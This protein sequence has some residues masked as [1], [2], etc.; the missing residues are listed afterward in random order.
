MLGSGHDI[1]SSLAAAKFA[2]HISRFLVPDP[3]KSLPLCP[4]AKRLWQWLFK[5]YQ[6]VFKTSVAQLFR[7]PF[8]LIN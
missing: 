2:R 1:T 3:D 5:Y 7:I 6:N 4:P 8:N